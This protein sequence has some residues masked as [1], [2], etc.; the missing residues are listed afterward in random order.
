MGNDLAAGGRLTASAGARLLYAAVLAASLLTGCGGSS[1]SSGSSTAPEPPAEAVLPPV[2][3][4]AL[5]VTQ[6]A[7]LAV[8]QYMQGQL[9]AQRIPGATVVVVKEGQVIYARGYGYANLA[10]ALPVKSED[11]FEIGSITKSF[12]ASAIMLLVQDGK[13]ALDDKLE[14]YIDGSPAQWSGI[15]IRQVLNHTAGIQRDADEATLK[16]VASNQV[17]GEDALL[18]R[19]K[20]YPLTG[21]PG[22]KFSYSNVG[23]YLIGFVIRKVSG[24]HYFDFLQECVFTPLGMSTARLIAPNLSSSGFATGYTIEN[25]R[26]VAVRMTDAQLLGLSLAAGGIQLSAMDMAKWDAA[27]YTEKILKKESLDQMW[28]NSALVQAASGTEPDIYYGLGWQLRTQGGMRWVYH[29]GGMP[30]HVSEMIRYPDQKM[31]VIVLLNLD[32]NANPRTVGRS[33]AR[34]FDP[35][36]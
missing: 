23:Y 14:Q 18:A 24:K 15:T 13:M 16:A 19:I 26:R 34:L 30:G 11:R 12:A 29:S 10:S 31:T 6:T 25:N 32:G 17:I 22:A 3:T 20:G 2:T 36:L 33:V 5:G 27:L 7:N 8:D 21:A 35:A 4:A 9:V 1:G 28:T